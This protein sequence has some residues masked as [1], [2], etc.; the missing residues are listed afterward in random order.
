MLGLA[1]G[2]SWLLASFP[3]P[4]FVLIPAGTYEV[5]KREYLFNP[6]RKVKLAAFEIA[7]YD[8]TNADFEAFVKATHYV[9]DA[10]KRHDSMVFEP[11]LKEFR[12]IQDPTAYWRFPNGITR[13]GI[14]GKMDH[15]VTGISFHDGE[16]YCKWAGVRLPTL[17]EWEVASRAGAKTDYFWGD[18][19]G[20]IGKYANVWHGRDHLKPDYSDGYMYTSPVGHFQP[21]PLGLYDIYG[22][23]FQFCSGRM[24]NDRS[25]IGVHARGGSWWCSR[26]ACCFFN[27]VDIG[28]VNIHASFSNQGFRV[29]KTAEY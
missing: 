28:T 29:A 23:V 3:S 4:E 8:V 1:L 9:T 16:E 24:P 19:P 20:Q 27:S 22:N 25:P 21:N 10:E 2:V 6:R 17:D 26:N 7:R 14:E 15:P 18:D 13:G 5:G 12:W 11:P